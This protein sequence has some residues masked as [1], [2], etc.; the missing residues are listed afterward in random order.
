MASDVD[1]TNVQRV[2]KYEKE[3]RSKLVLETGPRKEKVGL[4]NQPI[5]KTGDPRTNL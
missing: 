5:E 2:T 3:P 4:E 1:V